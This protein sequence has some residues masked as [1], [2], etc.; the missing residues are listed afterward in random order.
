M[1]RPRLFFLF[2]HVHVLI[3]PDGPSSDEQITTPS[4]V[5]VVCHDHRFGTKMMH[6]VR[7]QWLVT[8]RSTI[9]GVLFPKPGGKLPILRIVWVVGCVPGQNTLPLQEIATPE[10]QCPHKTQSNENQERWNQHF[11][12]SRRFSL[13]SSASFAS[14][15]CKPVGGLPAPTFEIQ[16]RLTY[17]DTF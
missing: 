4:D 13:R 11:Q 1:G 7:P 12:V 16:T 17:P 9:G 8:P 14:A 2:W 3:P 5:F 10:M 6:R 15:V